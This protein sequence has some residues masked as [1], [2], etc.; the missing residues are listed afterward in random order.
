MIA[1]AGAFIV[2]STLFSDSAGFSR[3]FA[4]GDFTNTIRIGLQLALVGAI[5]A[6]S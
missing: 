4:A 2:C 1:V 3:S 6:K 5:R